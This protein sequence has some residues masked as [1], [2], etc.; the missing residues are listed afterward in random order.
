MRSGAS[1]PICIFCRTSDTRG[2][3][4]VGQGEWSAI[5]DSFRSAFMVEEFVQAQ[6]L[7]RVPKNE[8]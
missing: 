6:V 2:E 5:K 4:G 1:V 8:G 7:W 3:E